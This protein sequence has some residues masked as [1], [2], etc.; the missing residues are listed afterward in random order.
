MQNKRTEHNY[1][2]ILK[3]SLDKKLRILDRIIQL[4][5]EQE[6]V[7]KSDTVDYD[8]FDATIEDK[9]E[10]INE[11]QSL[12]AGFQSVYD[13][14]KE[15]LLKNKDVFRDDICLMQEKIR[16]ITEK[17]MDIQSQEARNKEAFQN[18]VVSS[19]KEIKTAKTANKVASSYYQSMNRLNVVESQ[20][21]DTK[22]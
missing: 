16:E 9:E 11:L 1:I 21:L 6:S 14:V 12:D 18:R 10:C 19:K 17:S 22:K 20:F 8:R 4:N 13:R 3:D 7:L 15:M 5:A 2:D